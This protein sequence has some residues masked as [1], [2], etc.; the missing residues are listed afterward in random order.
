[1]F[2]SHQSNPKEVVTYKIPPLP[3]EKVADIIDYLDHDKKIVIGE[4]VTRIDEGEPFTH[5]QFFAIL[6][7][8][9]EKYPQT[10]IQITTNGTLLSEPMVKR[11]TD[12][13]PIEL[14]LSLNS[15][16][17][18]DEL[19]RDFTPVAAAAAALLAKWAIPYNGS[20]VGMPHLVGWPD[21]YD[22]CRVLDGENAQTIRLFIPGCTR[23]SPWLYP[24]DFDKEFIFHTNMLTEE[25]TTPIVLEPYVPDNLSAVIEGV[26]AGS[27]AARSGLV[28]GDIIKTVNGKPMRSRVDAFSALMNNAES[29]LEVDRSGQNML[30]DLSRARWARPGVVMYQD[31]DID[32]IDRISQ[33]VTEKKAARAAVL[34]SEL[35]Y[36]LWEKLFPGNSTVEV[37]AVGSRFF[38]GTIK[39]AGLLTVADYQFVIDKLL[40]TREYN[41]FFLPRISFDPAGRDLKGVSY[42]DLCTLGAEIIT[43]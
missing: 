31:V 3:L 15:A 33:I 1:M 34:V 32:L 29:S 7:L 37:Q 28:R 42:L 6:D 4:S 35:A 13:Q 12:Y 38:G 2:C 9:R 40:A 41:I 30:I 43:M 21:I 5:P 24:A 26:I 20:I 16:A 36:P 39:A 23:Y 17:R 25:L 10:P 11:L 14:N 22:T 18:R 8:I 27:P 19:M